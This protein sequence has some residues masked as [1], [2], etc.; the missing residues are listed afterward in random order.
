MAE[1]LIHARDVQ[2]CVCE[3]GAWHIHVVYTLDAEQACEG[4]RPL[5]DLQITASFILLRVSASS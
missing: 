1:E 5:I 3:Q 4:S 2:V